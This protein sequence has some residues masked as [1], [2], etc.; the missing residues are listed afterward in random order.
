M[1]NVPKLLAFS[2]VDVAESVQ[3]RLNTFFLWHG[4][5]SDSCFGLRGFLDKL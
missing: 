3:G 4:V 5:A 2:T 1:N